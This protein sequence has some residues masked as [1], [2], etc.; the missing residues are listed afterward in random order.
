[1]KRLL[2]AITLALGST[3]AN[4]QIVTGTPTVVDGDTLTMAGTRFRLDGIDAVEARQTCKRNG[5]VWQ[6]GQEAAAFLAKLVA[7]REVICEERDIDKYGRI[8]ATC[9]AG[10]VDLARSMVDAGYAVALPQFSDAYVEIE[11][12]RQSLGIGIWGSEFVMPSAYRAA[13]P[14]AYRRPVAQTMR[15]ARPS[16]SSIFFR[17]CAEARVAGAAPIYR[18][19]P[20]YRPEMDGDNDGIACEPYRGH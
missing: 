13:N 10:G 15:Q 18:G 11:A 5:Q 3:V 12:R 2:I 8:V 4:A 1:M 17:N 7:D 14:Q 20:G 9:R 6:C 19:Q 16:R